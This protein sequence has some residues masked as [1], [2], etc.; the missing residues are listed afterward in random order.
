MCTYLYAGPSAPRNVRFISRSRSSI[1]IKWLRPDSTNGVILSYSIQVRETEGGLELTKLLE[2]PL[3]TLEYN[4]TG[5]MEYVEYRI[6]VFAH[7]DKGRGEESVPIIVR[8]L[9]HRKVSFQVSLSFCLSL[10]LSLSLC[11]SL[12]LSLSLSHSH[13]VVSLTHLH[14][15][16][17]YQ[18][19]PSLFFSSLLTFL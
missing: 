4:I 8:T 15:F 1:F 11:L 6:V 18:S 2:L 17:P 10:S 3:N 9:E 12:S 7:T 13:S 19:L 14:F 5:L 16:A